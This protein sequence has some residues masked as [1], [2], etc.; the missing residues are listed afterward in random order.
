MKTLSSVMVQW[1]FYGSSVR[2]AYD[3]VYGKKIWL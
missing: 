2:M 3:R 1:S